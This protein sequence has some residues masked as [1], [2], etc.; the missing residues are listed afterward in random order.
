MWNPF[1][2]S[3]SYVDILSGNLFIHRNLDD[4]KQFEQYT[5]SSR[6]G[7]ALPIGVDS[8]VVL[9]QEGIFHFKPP[10]LLQQIARYPL[11]S[12][13]LRPNDG[14]VGPDGSLW[15][16]LMA[17]DHT[18]GA[19]SL[20]KFNG[21]NH[22]LVLDDLTIPNGLDW[23]G[24]TFFFVNGPTPEIR[25][26]RFEGNDIIGHI[27]AL[28]TTQTPDGLTLDTEGH[29]WVAHWGSAQVSETDPRKGETSSTHPV[30]GKY[31]TSI[32]ITAG[33]NPKKFITAAC[34]E[35]FSPQP[36]K[37]SH[38]HFGGVFV[39]RSDNAGRQ[40]QTLG[41]PLEKQES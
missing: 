26:Y 13:G 39:S 18:P 30:P 11:D 5:L 31:P 12:L 28:P 34:T 36:H 9:I 19:G 17:E 23:S 21:Q 35:C 37:D 4:G 3:L 15:F 27:P 6:L 8:Y 24:D 14:K 33:R 32:A 22:T 2:N 29:L 38:E 16:S 20:W 7:A 1:D 41:F 10:A 40:P 25:R